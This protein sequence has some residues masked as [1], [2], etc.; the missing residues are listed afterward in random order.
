MVLMIKI[1]SMIRVGARVLVVDAVERPTSEDQG[2]LFCLD[3]DGEDF[4]VRPQ[5]VDAIF[6]THGDSLTNAKYQEI[7][8]LTRNL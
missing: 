1:G 3:C 7:L 5:D 4:E 8:D 2:N 6:N